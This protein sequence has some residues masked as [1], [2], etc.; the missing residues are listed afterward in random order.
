VLTSATFCLALLVVAPNPESGAIA[1]T[2]APERAGPAKEPLAGQ[3][4][5]GSEEA[6]GGGEV[7]SPEVSYAPGAKTLPWWHSDCDMYPH[8]P[9]FP[10]LH[11]N[12]YF[13]PYGLEQLRR[14][15]QFVASWG[16]DPR[17]PYANTVFRRVYQETKGGQTGPPAKKESVSPPT[18]KPSVPHGLPS[19]AGEE[20]KPVVAPPEPPPTKVPL[21]TK[22]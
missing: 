13:R 1:P 9:Y 4:M 21:P 16:G 10:S 20:A 3:P 15:Q 19:Q 7:Y 18:P 8:Y 5:A 12:Y 2:P 22:P 17:D 6:P 14:Q 11:G